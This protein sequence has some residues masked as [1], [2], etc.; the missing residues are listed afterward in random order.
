MLISPGQIIRLVGA[1]PRGVDE[2]CS[3]LGMTK[4]ENL[5]LWEASEAIENKAS[6]MSIARDTFFDVVIIED[7]THHGGDNTRR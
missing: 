7:S 3:Q 1:E 5:H 4:Q 2:S 6:A